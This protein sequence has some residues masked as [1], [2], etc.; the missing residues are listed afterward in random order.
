LRPGKTSETQSP[1]L[2]AIG[3]SRSSSPHLSYKY[4]NEPK[5]AGEERHENVSQKWETAVPPL[6][7]LWNHVNIVRHQRS[8]TA[9]LRPSIFS[10]AVTLAPS[11]TDCA[12]L[13]PTIMTTNVVVDTIKLAHEITKVAVCI[14]LLLISLRRKIE[15]EKLSGWQF[16]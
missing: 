6:L 2:R 1:E 14:F 10:W 13:A 7:I 5:P 16:N 4:P 15:G 9:R 3:G 8:A 11:M 12:C